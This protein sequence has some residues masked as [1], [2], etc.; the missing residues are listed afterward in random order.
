MYEIF[1]KSKFLAR[2]RELRK[3]ST[4][5]EQKLWFY[6]KGN[7]LGVKFRRQQGIGPYVA[8]FYCKEKNL[9]I[10]VDGS[11]HLDAKEYDKERDA[12]METL[13]M[14]VL[15]FWNSEID[16]NI[17]TVLMKVRETVAPLRRGAVARD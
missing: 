11:Q 12:Y 2:R 9:I 17:E 1:N 16:K 10:E 14:K 8:D 3:S 6:L 13:G 4:P 7:K 5:Q 15:R